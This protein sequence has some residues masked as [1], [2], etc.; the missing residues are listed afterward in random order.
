MLCAYGTY[1]L[2]VLS[3]PNAACFVA[4]AVWILQ[5]AKG[6]IKVMLYF[7]YAVLQPN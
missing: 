2:V 5:V 3:S 7:Y 1:W 6:L 4:L